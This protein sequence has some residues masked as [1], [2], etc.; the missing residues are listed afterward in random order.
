VCN[1]HRGLCEGVVGDA[2]QGSVVEF[3]TLYE[4]DP[5]HVVVAVT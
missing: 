2:G 1:L 5:C 4:P 3:S